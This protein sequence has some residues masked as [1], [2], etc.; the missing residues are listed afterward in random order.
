MGDGRMH[1]F[2]AHRTHSVGALGPDMSRSELATTLFFQLKPS[3]DNSIAH[4]ITRWKRFRRC[5]KRKTYQ[6]HTDVLGRAI[7]V[8][9]MGRHRDH[10]QA[11]V[12]R[13]GHVGQPVQGAKDVLSKAARRLP[14]TAPLYDVR[15]DERTR[16][17][18]FSRTFRSSSATANQ[19]DTDSV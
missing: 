16:L 12:I 8:A 14:S 5:H 10:Y 18:A 1:I 13:T 11:I 3:N 7:Q 9:D 6:Y 2:P 15:S 4:G 17:G 19:P